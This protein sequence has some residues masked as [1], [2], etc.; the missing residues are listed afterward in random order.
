M[1]KMEESLILLIIIS[2]ALGVACWLAFLWGVKRGEF[3][4]PERPKYRMLDD[5]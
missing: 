5:D 4:D 2:G 3:E 1:L